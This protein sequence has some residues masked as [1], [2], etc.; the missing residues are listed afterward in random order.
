MIFHLMCSKKLV[1]KLKFKIN[2][3]KK[4]V[5][6]KNVNRTSLLDVSLNVYQDLRGFT[7]SQMLSI[8]LRRLLDRRAFM[9]FCLKFTPWWSRDFRQAF[10][11]CSLQILLK[12][13]WASLHSSSLAFNLNGKKQSMYYKRKITFKNMQIFLSSPI[14][15]IIKSQPHSVT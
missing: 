6:L 2:K 10:S 4:S 7:S 8:S 9:S 12:P 15:K 11:Y 3:N 1:G 14:K 5:I 13:C